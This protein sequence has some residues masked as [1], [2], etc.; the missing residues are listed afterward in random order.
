[1]SDV[2]FLTYKEKKT[3]QQLISDVFVKN[4]VKFDLISEKAAIP[5]LEDRNYYYKLAC[6]RKNFRRDKKNK[7]IDLDFQYLVSLSKIDK[8]LRYILLQMTLEIEHFLKVTILKDISYNTQVDGYAI[9]S[10]YISSYNAKHS[11]PI[12]IETLIERGK[13]QNS[14]NHGI[15]HKVSTNGH[16]IA[17]WQLLEI[18]QMQELEYFFEYYFTRYSNPLINI[19]AYK[20]LL[21]SSRYIRNAAAHNSPI[22]VNVASSPSNAFTTSGINKQYINKLLKP[23]FTNAKIALAVK[24]THRFRDIASVFKLY[25]LLRIAPTSSTDSILSSL[26]S[27]LNNISTAPPFPRL[28][29]DMNMF[30]SNLRKLFVDIYK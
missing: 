22:L 15:Y 23:H 6:Y 26:E 28:N 12:S 11:R 5:Y 1:M 18:L 4:G 17:V 19:S 29:N 3:A 9:V 8:E 21:I 10:D 14:V 20:S 7:Y 2:I 16:Y 25:N 30:F 24:P 27:L 13:N